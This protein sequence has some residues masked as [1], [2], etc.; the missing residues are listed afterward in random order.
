MI[1]EYLK[2]EHAVSVANT[3]NALRAL[4]GERVAFI[5][6]GYEGSLTHY[7]LIVFESGCSLALAS[8]GSYWINNKEVTKRLITRKIHEIE[9]TA[10]E[11]E[12][13]KKAYELI[14]GEEKNENHQH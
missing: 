6:F 13:A 1:E 5:L 3:T 2:K 7:N 11:I 14:F 10:S 4:R 8:N 12:A 9:K